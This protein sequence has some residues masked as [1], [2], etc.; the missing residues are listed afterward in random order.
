MRYPKLISLTIVDA[1]LNSELTSCNRYMIFGDSI[2]SITVFDE[3]EVQYSATIIGWS[4]QDAF[5]Q[6]LFELFQ[7]CVDIARRYKEYAQAM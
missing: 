4:L 3:Q 7:P 6:T 1:W 2:E 5:V